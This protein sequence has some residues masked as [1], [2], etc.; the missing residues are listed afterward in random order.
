[1][2]HGV[3]ERHLMCLKWMVIRLAEVVRYETRIADFEGPLD[4]LLHLLKASKV[5]IYDIKISEITRQYLMYI[6]AMED[7][8][9]EVASEYLVMAAELVRI[10]S[11]KLIPLEEVEIESDFEEESEEETLIRRLVEYQKY[12]E[13]TEDL[14]ELEE[15]RGLFYT[16]P[17]IDFSEYADETV[18]LDAGTSVS[19]LILAFEKVMRRQQLSAPRPTRIMGRKIT[20]EE[21]VQSLSEQLRYKKRVSFEYLFERFDREYV[22]VTFLAVLELAKAGVISIV[23]DDEQDA[24][25]LMGGQANHVLQI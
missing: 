16:K 7:M 17:A 10:K 24:F 13:V 14:R 1:M 18:R 6:Q 20:V 8:Q 11:K 2:A 22:V 3:R 23:H 15:A 12:K 4:L 25:W 21:R 9:L 5:D 19:D